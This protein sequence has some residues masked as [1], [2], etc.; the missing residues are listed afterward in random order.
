MKKIRI[1]FFCVGAWYLLNFISLLP[2]LMKN[3]LPRFYPA[4][5]VSSG[6]IA[7]EALIDIWFLFGLLYGTVGIG[8]FLAA[9]RPLE[10]HLF[11]ILVVLIE[12]IAGI[13]WDI[14][15]LTRAITPASF[16]YFFIAVHV[17]IIGTACWVYPRK[18]VTITTAR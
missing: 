9:R 15:S 13:I 16:S 14:Y 2:P 17:L 10:N 8:L 18:P 1:W 4:I 12:I 5:E 7:Y 11:V 3:Q 6:S